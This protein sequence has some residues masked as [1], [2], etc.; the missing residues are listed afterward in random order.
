MSYYSS[1][2]SSTAVPS[3]PLPMLNTGDA[4]P[5]SD[6]SKIIGLSL[7]IGSGLLIGSSFV[8]KKKGLIN[9]TKDGM[10]AGEGHAYL[11]SV[12][13]WTG[14]LMMVVGEVC[15]FVA[16]AFV[17][18][19]LVTPLGA[20]SVVI[21]AILSSIFLRERLNLQGKIGCAQ[22]IVGATIIVFHAP[23]QASVKTIQEFKHLMIQPGFLSWMALII[24]ASL[25]LIIKAGPRWGKE[26]MMIY[27]GVCSLIGS[28]SVVSTQG[29][30]AAI[31]HNISTG[32]AQFDNWFIY[33]IIVFMVV[34]LLT[35]INYLNKALNLFNT[36]MV[37]PTYYVTFTSTTIVTSAIFYQ[38]FNASVTAIITVCLGF[39]VICGGVLLLQTSKPVVPLHMPGSSAASI[40]GT[41]S[42][43]DIEP[44]AADMRASPFSSIRRIT[45]DLR[46]PSIIGTIS[47]GGV[48]A[49]GN[50][51][52]FQSSPLNPRAESLLQRKRAAS[53]AALRS[54]PQS[55]ISGHH[56]LA[57]PGG[58]GAGSVAGGATAFYPSTT[59]A[60][61]TMVMGPNGSQIRLQLCEIVVS[62]DRNETSRYQVY[63]P[64]PPH[65]D[66][67]TAVPPSLNDKHG[68]HIHY[69]Q[70]QQ[71]RPRANST[72]FKHSFL[73]PRSSLLIDSRSSSIRFSDSPTQASIDENIGEKD[74]HSAP[75][76]PKYSS[77]ISGSLFM[78]PKLA[79]SPPTPD[80]STN[81]ATLS[82]SPPS[83]EEESDP[84][85]ASQPAVRAAAGGAA[86][87]GGATKPPLS[88]PM[89]VGG[90]FFT[91]PK[92]RS[93]STASGDIMEMNDPGHAGRSVV[94]TIEPVQ[95]QPLFSL[96]VPPPPPH[97]HQ[98]PKPTLSTV[99][100]A[101]FTSAPLNA[102]DASHN[103]HGQQKEGSSRPSDATTAAEGVDSHGND[104]DK[105]DDGKDD[106]SASTSV[107]LDAAAASKPKRVGFF[108]KL[109]SKS[110][111]KSA[112][113]PDITTA[114][115]APE[116]GPGSEDPLSTTPDSPTTSATPLVGST[117]PGTAAASPSSAHP[118]V[119]N[120]TNH[121]TRISEGEEEEEE[122]EERE[123][124]VPR[125]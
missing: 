77:P 92:F 31:V 32:E 46:Q 53:N 34:T 9:C 83:A 20:L 1:Y 79:V 76:S 56:H 91:R 11:K 116:S 124:N 80:M 113:A 118:I 42:Y 78:P 100:S 74:E 106:K 110:P 117:T 114:T 51:S 75:S 86:G 66:L 105:Q 84:N 112:T 64:V 71:L 96:Y 82:P 13:W 119:F 88:G 54:R 48:G 68:D 58:A 108:G 65:G 47:S 120:R 16:Y 29:L 101:S 50:H 72:G 102:S 95:Q 109:F 19:I 45:R 5:A 26:H 94:V 12:M 23:E 7:A 14:M 33:F 27:I 40:I 6:S 30:G 28:L 87:A 8:F 70:Q 115:L 59:G 25:V 57:V 61:S 38:G 107:A 17:Q 10:L 122:E 90:S 2:N 85:G 39:L 111:P 93:P 43:D 15:N 18:P 67:A 55:I 125:S 3:G 62:D 81:A 4:P 41:I 97:P 98:T 37:T 103:G 36:A 44:T 21:C 89:A 63:R 22:C 69:Q 104:E 49:A 99:N 35:E 121:P 123:V 24:V 52:V 73:A 60:Y